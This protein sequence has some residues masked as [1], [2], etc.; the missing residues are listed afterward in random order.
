MCRKS[1]LFSI[2]KQIR[3]EEDSKKYYEAKKMLRE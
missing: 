1:E 2:W 3:N